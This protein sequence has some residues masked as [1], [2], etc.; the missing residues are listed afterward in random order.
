MKTYKKIWTL[1][2]DGYKRIDSNRLITGYAVYLM[3]CAQA[4]YDLESEK[5]KTISEWLESEI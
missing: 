5:V 3:M 4:G 1:N 2:P